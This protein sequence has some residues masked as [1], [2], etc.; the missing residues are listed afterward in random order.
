MLA[1]LDR[2]CREAEQ[3]VEQGD[4]ILVLT[5]RAVGPERVPISS[6]LACGAV[7]HHLVRQAK[8]TR[9]GLGAGNR[10]KPAKCITIAC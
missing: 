6:L 3:A 1:C 9:V 4:A 7:H 10:A 5:D 8:R 2:I